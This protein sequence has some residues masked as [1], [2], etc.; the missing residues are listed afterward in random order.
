VN[1]EGR[2]FG[3][4]LDLNGTAPADF[5][6]ADRGMERVSLFEARPIMTAT[7][8]ADTSDAAIEQ[9]SIVRHALF[10]TATSASASRIARAS[11]RI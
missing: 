5:S 8:Y 6:D 9:P 3:L 10:K 1:L 4:A 7:R 11:I 2:D